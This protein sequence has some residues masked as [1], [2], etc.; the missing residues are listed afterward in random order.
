M[1]SSAYLT[2]E[3]YRVNILKINQYL[4]YYNGKRKAYPIH[5]TKKE[6]ENIRKNGIVILSIDLIE[7]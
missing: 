1:S 7:I 2:E 6:K 5:K 4:G 3:K